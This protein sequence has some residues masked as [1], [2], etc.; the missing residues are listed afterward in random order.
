MTYSAEPE[1]GLSYP[2]RIWIS[3]SS[4]FYVVKIPLYI[5]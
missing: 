2:I 4:V 1:L 3:Q 5:T